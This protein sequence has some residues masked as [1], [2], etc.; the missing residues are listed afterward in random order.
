MEGR[1]ERRALAAGGDV[2]AAE[3]RDHVDMRE[4]GEQGRVVGLAR[5]AA[6]GAVPHGLAVYTDRVHVGGAQVGG[7]L[8]LVA[9]DRV[10]RGQRIGG[11]RFALDL[12]A[13]GLLQREQCLAQRI[14]EAHEGF[15]QHGRRFAGREAHGDAVA[16]VHAGAGHQPEIDAIGGM[17][18]LGAL[19]WIGRHGFAPVV[20]RAGDMPGRGCPDYPRKR[21]RR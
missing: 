14:G 21:A 16:A 1:R 12:V 17:A 6:L 11:Q 13:A 8:Q 18:W 20:M 3:I 2:A 15:G 5:V 19:G 7:A 10:A 4:F 9:A